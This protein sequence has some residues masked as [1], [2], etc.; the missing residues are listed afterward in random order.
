MNLKMGNQVFH[1]VQ[2]P[3][4]WGTRAILQDQQGRLS[5]VDL[6]GDKAKLEIV[7]DEPAPGI[8]FLPTVD[9][10]KILSKREG[11][12]IYSPRHKTLTSISLDL[13]ECQI[14]P[15]ETR[16]GSNI[17]SGNT[18]TGHGVGIAVTKNGMAIGAPL[19]KGLADLVI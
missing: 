4:L 10:Y 16:V 19:P 9:G 18:F 8:E 17:L 15:W 2:I 13:P 3:L 7:G 1:N 6:A 5:V 11:L 14:G 12:Y